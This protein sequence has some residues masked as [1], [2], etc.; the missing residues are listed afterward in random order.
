MSN[1]WRLPK[2]ER[3]L[4]TAMLSGK[5]EAFG[6]KNFEEVRPKELLLVYTASQP[7]EQSG[8]GNI[9]GGRDERRC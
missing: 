4:S 7:R 6:V 2:D 9:D 3:N 8:P 5:L 1:G